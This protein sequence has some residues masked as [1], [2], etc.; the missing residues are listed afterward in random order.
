VRLKLESEQTSGSF[1]IRG[2][3]NKLLALTDDE[4]QRGIVTASTG[5]HALAVTH[6]LAVLERCLRMPAEIYL[7]STVAAAKLELLRTLKAPI[8]VT[9][10]VDCIGSEMAAIKAAADTGAVYISPYN[11]LHVSQYAWLTVSDAI[12]TT[13]TLARRLSLARAPLGWR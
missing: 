13:I 1:K 8:R 11:D 2:A 9:E 12:V 10:E 6:A 7:P 3:V 5:N 4:L